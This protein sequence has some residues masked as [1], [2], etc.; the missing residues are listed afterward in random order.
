MSRRQKKT[1]VPILAHHVVDL[2]YVSTGGNDPRQKIKSGHRYQVP[3]VAAVKKAVGSKLLVSAVG[4]LHSGVSAQDL[5]END[6]ADVI[7]VGW[8]FQKN[9]GQVWAMA[10]ELG[11][12][13]RVA[14]Q[15]E[16]PFAGRPD[17]A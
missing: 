14:H 16:C 3:F 2:L 5:L 12:E 6:Q 13:I 11:V 17:T 7:V 4:G 8:Q 9:P 10:E 1:L 15:M